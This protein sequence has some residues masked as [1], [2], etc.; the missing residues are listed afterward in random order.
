MNN[1]FQVETSPAT[2]GQ[3]QVE[4]SPA[5]AGIDPK[6]DSSRVIEIS[7]EV[8]EVTPTCSICLTND[9]EYSYSCCF[10]D[11]TMKLCKS[12]IERMTMYAIFE[13]INAAVIIDP[14]HGFLLDCPFC[15]QNYGVIYDKTSHNSFVLEDFLNIG[16]T[17]TA[18]RIADQFYRAKIAAL[19]VSHLNDTHNRWLNTRRRISAEVL[20]PL[21][22]LIDVAYTRDVRRRPY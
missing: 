1:Q 4:T 18:L 8:L 21:A 19:E 5:A 20:M 7:P 11:G 15:R 12:C 16:Q 10:R 2:D 17:R 13:E 22:R 14:S 3:L 9:A 6:Y